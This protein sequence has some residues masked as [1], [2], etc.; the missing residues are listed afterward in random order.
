MLVNSM[1]S[2]PNFFIRVVKSWPCALDSNVAQIVKFSWQRKK[3][4][5]K[6]ENAGLRHFS[7]SHI[8]IRVVNGVQFALDSKVTPMLKFL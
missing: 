1:L 7:F 5:G 8:F 2:F 3:K 6:G 4:V